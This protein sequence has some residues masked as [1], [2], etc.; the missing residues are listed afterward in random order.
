MF[1]QQYFRP[2]ILKA[3]LII[4]G[5]TFKNESRGSNFDDFC[6][7]Y[8]GLRQLRIFLTR[9]IW[10]LLLFF[11]IATKL[12]LCKILSENFQLIFKPSLKTGI[13]GLGL[14]WDFLIKSNSLMFLNLR[15]TLRFSKVNCFSNFY[16]VPP[17]KSNN[18]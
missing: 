10:I 16:F 9:I 14:V 15:R 6:A 13:V 8:K 18:D 12:Y 5:Y 3:W 4:K 7:N 17:K 2:C 1:S 11:K